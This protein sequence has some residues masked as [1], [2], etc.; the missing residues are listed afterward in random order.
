MSRMEVQGRGHQ[1]HAQRIITRAAWLIVLGAVRTRLVC[2]GRVQVAGFGIRQGGP[3]DGCHMRCF[4]LLPRHAQLASRR[5]MPSFLMFELGPAPKLGNYFTARY[6]L[7][8][9]GGSRSP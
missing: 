3:S 5:E 7:L 9:A 4:L 8:S 2:R 1:H 6:K